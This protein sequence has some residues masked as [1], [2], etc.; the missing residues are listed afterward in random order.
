MPIQLSL[1]AS[2]M[3]SRSAHATV[4][5]PFVESNGEEDVCR[6]GSPIGNE[7]VIGRP[8]KVGIL[9]VNIGEAVNLRKTD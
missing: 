6:L 2:R 4:A 1:N 8:L 7:G 5:V 3:Y 9:E